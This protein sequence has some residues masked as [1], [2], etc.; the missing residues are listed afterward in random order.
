MF[1]GNFGHDINVATKH[2]LTY[3]RKNPPLNK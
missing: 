2:F 3:G 1:V